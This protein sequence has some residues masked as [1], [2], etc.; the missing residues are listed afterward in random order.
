ML[1]EEYRGN[2]IFLGD[3]G[4][5]E[6]TEEACLGVALLSF[7]SRPSD[8]GMPVDG[9]SFPFTALRPCGDATTG[10]S[11]SDC[12]EDGVSP[13]GAV[14]RQSCG[15]GSTTKQQGVFDPESR[16]SI[17][18]HWLHGLLHVQVVR[19]I[20]VGRLPRRPLSS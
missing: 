7:L 13:A 3:K 17:R 1:P 12:A 15:G 9:V 11:V 6:G 2:W 8:G 18:P 14:H 5:V 20:E 10:L 16:A 4:G 19:A